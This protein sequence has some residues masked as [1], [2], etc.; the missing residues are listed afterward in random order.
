[1]KSDTGRFNRLWYS[2]LH[3]AEEAKI[4]LSAR[5]S[6]EID[7]SRSSVE[8][9]N[10]KAIDDYIQITRSEFEALIKD[11]VDNTAAML[12]KILTRNSLRP[13][14]LKFVLMVGGS[15]YIPFV[16]K[17]IEE[18]LGI[19]VNTGIDPTNAI[20]IGAAYFAATKE[21]D[22]GE[23]AGTRRAVRCGV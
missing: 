13:Q 7:L 1:M 2:L 18:L 8:D 16:R 23:G 4:E 12:K 3:R 6:A 19:P 21:I 14:D 11:A 5:T 20:V 15:T 9:E 22:L 10:G 17:R